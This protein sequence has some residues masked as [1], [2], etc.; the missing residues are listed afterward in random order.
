MAGSCLAA[1]PAPIP[2]VPSNK[3]DHGPWVLVLIVVGFV[4]AGVATMALAH[5][6]SRPRDE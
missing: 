2:A 5:R 6:N 4:L 3:P 1:T